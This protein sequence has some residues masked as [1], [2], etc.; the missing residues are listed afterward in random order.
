MG[1][2]APMLGRSSLTAP[3]R[4]RWRVNAVSPKQSSLA[5]DET[6]KE[7]ESC[8][9]GV[10]FE[11]ELKVIVNARYMKS[12]VSFVASQDVIEVNGR[13]TVSF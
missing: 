9:Y 11:P 6:V 2:P 7:F 13:I 4:G 10:D 1:G 8:Q 3:F 5:F 12:P